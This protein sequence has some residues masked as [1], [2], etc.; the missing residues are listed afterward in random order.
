MKQTLSAI[1]TFLLVFASN[2]SAQTSKRDFKI[3]GDEVVAAPVVSNESKAYKSFRRFYPGVSDEKWMSEK[4]HYF[5]TFSQND[6]KNK[7]VFTRNGRIDYTLKMYYE[8]DLP[9]SVRRSVKSAYFDYDITNVQ[10]LVV[11]NNRI[12]LVKITDGKSWKTIRV[13]NGELEEI[14]YYVKAISPCR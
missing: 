11:K 13:Q 3:T 10:E 9:S 8:K 14:E 4:D 1:V 6:I 2:A 7:V 12:Y 5:V